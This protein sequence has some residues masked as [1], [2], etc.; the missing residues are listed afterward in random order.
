MRHIKK[1][2]FLLCPPIIIKLFKKNK[3]S[4]I[5]KFTSY[6][7]AQEASNIYYDKKSTERFLGPKNVEVSGRFNILPILV[8]SLKKSN[9][10]KYKHDTIDGKTF[11]H[12]DLLF[13]K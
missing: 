2:I 7:K 8:L 11:F 6:K 13:K 4:Y 5:S 12:K 1:L 3:Y 10:N 9:I